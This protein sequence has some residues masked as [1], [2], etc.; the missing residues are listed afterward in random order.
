MT[1]FSV[2]RTASAALAL[3]ALSLATM[4]LST[5]AAAQ[6]G[7]TEKANPQFLGIDLDTGRA[8]YNGRNSGV[9]CLYRTVRVFNT[10]TGY[11]EHRRVRR[12]GRGLYL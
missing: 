4:G 1:R 11:F 9:Y 5:P 7:R 12:C 10:Y 3:L 8:Y 6:T 2:T